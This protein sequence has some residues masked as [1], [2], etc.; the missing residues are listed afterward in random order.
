[1]KMIRLSKPIIGKVE[2]GEILKVLRS[3]NLS[4]GSFVKRFEEEFSRYLG[5]KFSVGV[6]SGTTALDVALKTAGVREGSYVLTTPFSFIATANAIL[7][8]GAIPVFADINPVSFNLSLESVIENL[9]KNKKIKTLLLVHLFGLPCNMAEIKKIVN[10]FN[11]TL[12]EDCAQAV[13]AEFL[14]KK[15]GAFGEIS[16]FSFYATKNITSGEGGMAVCN[17]KKF[18]EALERYINHGSIRKNVH[19][20][21]GYNYRLTN[22]AAALG[23]SQLKK[24][25]GFNQKRIKNAGLFNRG[26]EKLDWLILPLVPR[27]YKHIFH[28]YTVRLKRG[29]KREDFIKYL[30]KKGIESGIFYPCPIYRQPLYR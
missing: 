13:G 26:L 3:G 17:K 30:K 15:A 7:Y 20:H 23:R 1:M 11:L 29:I 21:L 24:L 22:M 18:K 4:S 28:Q 5:M 8:Q 19:H 14:G 9:K 10:R 6:S 2:E 27:G 25:D 12:V 16:T